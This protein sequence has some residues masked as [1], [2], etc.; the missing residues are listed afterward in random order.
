MTFGA[1]SAQRGMEAYGEAAKQLAGGAAAKGTGIFVCELRA[2]SRPD[3]LG[4]AMGSQS[5]MSAAQSGSGK[6]MAGSGTSTGIR[7]VE[8]L[9]S[10]YGG[11]VDDWAKL[12]TAGN[13][14]AKDGTRFE[15]HWYENIKTGL[16]VEY[17]TKFLP[18][19]KKVS[20]IE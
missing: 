3:L 16:Q 11:A 13:Y 9:V 15:I 20:G 14:T 2:A 7:D 6:I 1:D 5:L 12:S 18:P 10:T 17:K 19:V 8:R 4:K